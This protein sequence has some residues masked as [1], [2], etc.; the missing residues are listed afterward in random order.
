MTIPESRFVSATRKPTNA[1]PGLKVKRGF[2]LAR[3]RWFKG[4][5]QAKGKEKSK[6]K[7]K[8]KRLFEITLTQSSR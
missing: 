1:N 8:S 6:S 2:H 4:L 7:L 3:Q 5:F